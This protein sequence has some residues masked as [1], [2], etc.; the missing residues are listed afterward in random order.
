MPGYGMFNGICGTVGQLVP[1]VS[2]SVPNP[3]RNVPNRVEGGACWRSD[4]A[5]Y[6]R[7]HMFG[8]QP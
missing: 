1:A 6:A 3:I 8:S 5:R 2:E 4:L 7:V